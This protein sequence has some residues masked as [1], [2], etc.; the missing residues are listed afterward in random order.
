[1]ST[2]PSF[3][4]AWLANYKASASQR[5]SARLTSQRRRRQQQRV[6]AAGSSWDVHPSI[7]RRICEAGERCTE[8]NR[9]HGFPPVGGRLDSPRS[10]GCARS[11]FPN[12]SA[13][14]HYPSTAGVSNNATL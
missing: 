11:S 3:L 13:D 5:R 6:D 2:P 1:M 4:T 12:P 9:Q 7:L 8:W 10:I 14:L